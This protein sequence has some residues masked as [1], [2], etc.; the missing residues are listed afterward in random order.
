[1][2]CSSKSSFHFDGFFCYIVTQGPVNIFVPFSGSVFRKTP[3]VRVDTFQ[4]NGNT[5][6]SLEISSVLGHGLWLQIVRTDTQSTLDGWKENLKVKWIVTPETDQA[7]TL[8]N[9]R[10]A[11]LKCM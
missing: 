10:A 11:V 2:F 6:F 5:I 1:M 4:N 9:N 8:L 7:Q 3:R